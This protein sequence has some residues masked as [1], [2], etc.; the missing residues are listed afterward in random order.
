[1]NT[2]GYNSMVGSKQGRESVMS[3]QLHAHNELQAILNQGFQ[4]TDNRKSK[5]DAVD[6]MARSLDSF[7]K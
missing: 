1:M 4:I 5:A 6:A 2:T 3:P 7:N